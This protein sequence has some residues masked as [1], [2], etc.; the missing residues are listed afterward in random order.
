MK[1]DNFWLAIRWL[2]VVAAV[3]AI[4]L[5]VFEL[6]RARV[7]QHVL[8]VERADFQ[9]S[10]LATPPTSGVWQPVTLPDDWHARGGVEARQG[11]YRLSLPLNVPPDRL[12]GIYLPSVNM[13][14]AVWL[15]GELLGDGG[16]FADPVARNWNRPLYFAIPNGLLRPAENL[17]HIRVRT[18]PALYGLLGSVH[19][20]PA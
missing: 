9:A 3:V 5:V 15:N 11:W 10:D 13:N 1:R 4:S 12:W 7:P 14:A 20:G 17:V 2:A 19:L 16:R 6:H 8:N 18:E